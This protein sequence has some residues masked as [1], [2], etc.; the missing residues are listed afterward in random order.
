MKSK[1]MKS[2]EPLPFDPKQYFKVM[3]KMWWLRLTGKMPNVQPPKETRTITADPESNIALGTIRYK[4]LDCIEG[5]ESEV[6]ESTPHLNQA[7]VTQIVGQDDGITQTSHL[8]LDETWDLNLSYGAGEY[9]SGFAVNAI[10]RGCH[11]FCWEWFCVQ[12]NGEAVKLQEQG[13]VRPKTVRTFENE[14]IVEIEFLTD[15]SIRT[16]S[17]EH[18]AQN[19]ANTQRPERRIVVL[20]GS[21]VVFPLVIDGELRLSG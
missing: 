11:D 1:A 19:P 21:S 20:Q 7:Y 17:F 18:L 2:G 3:L 4:V 5:T 13:K 8:F 10:R 14:D 15:I 6:K 9:K 16:S 12:P